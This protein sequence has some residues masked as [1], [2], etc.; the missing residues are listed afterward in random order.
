[1]LL[2]ACSLYLKISLSNSNNVDM[3][4]TGTQSGIE[5]SGSLVRLGG[6]GYSLLVMAF[7]DGGWLACWI[8]GDFMDSWR[9]A[10][11]SL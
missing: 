3:V 11:N 4:L 7:E 5:Y 10:G 2:I 9:Q 8:S 1:M 6:P